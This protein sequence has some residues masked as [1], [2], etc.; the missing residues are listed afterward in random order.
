MIWTKGAHQSA[1]FQTL[2]LD[3][4]CTL[5][6]SLKYI[7]FSQRN[8]EE[9]LYFMTLKIDAKFEEKLIF[10]CKKWQGFG[11]IWPEHLQVSKT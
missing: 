3:Q 7:K 9:L 5:I 10:C 4:I 11:E 2:Y 6:S 1:K 8:T